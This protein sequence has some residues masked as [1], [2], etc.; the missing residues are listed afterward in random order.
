VYGSKP[1]AKRGTD[2]RDKEK[3]EGEGN[4][5]API[6]RPVIR[7]YGPRARQISGGT[8]NKK[9]PG[10]KEQ[11]GDLL[12][13]PLS[14]GGKCMVGKGGF[15]EDLAARLWAGRNELSRERRRSAHTHGALRLQGGA[16]N[17]DCK[18]ASTRD[19]SV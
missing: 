10:G 14:A 15:H 9:C 8:I 3:E 13:P 16:A 6:K 11:G 2:I 1:T 4:T 12:I 7:Q 18:T 5:S 17:A 19:A